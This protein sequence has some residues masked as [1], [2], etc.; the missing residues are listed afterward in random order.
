MDPLVFRA[1]V[2]TALAL[3][4]DA[5][6]NTPPG[7]LETQ[8]MV[9]NRYPDLDRPDHPQS[10][11]R[12]DSAPVKT[13]AGVPTGGHL[14]EIGHLG[15]LGAPA[16]TEMVT[17]KEVSE[18]KKRIAEVGGLAGLATP[19]VHDLATKNR[20]YAGSSVGRGLS[21]FFHGAHGV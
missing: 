9:H 14:W 2:K 11:F 21:R 20:A 4:V 13:A 19:Y 18:K 5:W 8:A 6:N 16:A 7:Y 3:Q 10:D 15:L 1:F 17:G 12:E